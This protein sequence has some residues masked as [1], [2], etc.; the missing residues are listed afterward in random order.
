MWRA[1]W[2]NIPNI[3]VILSLPFVSSNAV[4]NVYV[5]DTTFSNNS[6]LINSDSNSSSSSVTV[7][8]SIINLLP[9]VESISVTNTYFKEN[10][11]FSS[12][13]IILG[14][15]D[16]SNRTTILQEYSGNEYVENTSNNNNN[17]FYGETSASPC[18]L[19]YQSLTFV[20]G[21]PVSSTLE[22]REGCVVT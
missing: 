10:T 1:V 22:E 3:G 2:R 21:Y 17:R 4:V 12:G 18:V 19:V 9:P 13:L 16:H 14:E 8:G 20:D 11:D 5:S 7:T 6:F 15:Y